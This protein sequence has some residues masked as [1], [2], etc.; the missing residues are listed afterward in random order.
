MRLPLRLPCTSSTNRLLTFALI[1]CWCAFSFFSYGVADDNSPQEPEQSVQGKPVILLTGFEPFGPGKPPNPSWEGIKELDNTDW[2]DFR[3][4]SRQMKVVWGAPLEQ[5]ETW[6]SEFKPA[7]IFSFGQGG[8]GSFAIESMARNVRGRGRDNLGELPAEPNIVSSGPASFASDIDSQQ[9]AALLT[10]TG[11]P[12]RVSRN[13]GRYLCEEA[14]YSLEYL[15]LNDQSVSSVM[16][17]H[18]PPM[19]S[20]LGSVTVDAQYVQQFVMATLANWLQL[21]Q[22]GQPQPQAAPLKAPDDPRL[23]EIEKLIR[24][25]FSTWSNQDIKAYGECFADQAVIQLIDR[26]G[27]IQTANL[28]PFLDGQRQAHR[29]AA[30]RLIEVPESIDIHLHARLANVIVFWK[31]T[32]GPARVDYGYDHFTLVKNKDGWRIVNLVYYGVDRAP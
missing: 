10:R 21:Q 2:N 30:N 27:S 14:L 13:A 24:R 4:V 32:D 20:Q 29:R 9:L 22:P 17:C 6:V 7:A 23:A 16:F 19:H 26:G 11:Y 18:V 8:S 31:L 1:C 12:T 5:L 25:Y 28:K 3:L 15:K